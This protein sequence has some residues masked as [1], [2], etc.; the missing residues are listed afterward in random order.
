MLVLVELFVAF[1]LIGLFTFGGGYAMIPMIQETVL[2]Q[3]SAVQEL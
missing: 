1:F 2:E 3:F